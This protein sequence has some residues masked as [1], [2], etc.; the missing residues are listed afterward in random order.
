MMRQRCAARILC[1]CLQRRVRGAFR[2]WYANTMN[3]PYPFLESSVIFCFTLRSKFYFHQ[4]FFS[5][6]DEF[7]HCQYSNYVGLKNLNT[8]I[9]D[10]L[11]MKALSEPFRK[12]TKHADVHFLF[13]A[14][15]LNVKFYDEYDEIKVIS[16][17]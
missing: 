9:L 7:V 2:I 16:T 4:T 15:S 14:L 6:E 5:F 13:F 10:S 1:E 11:R 8:D 3:R 17:T 12:L